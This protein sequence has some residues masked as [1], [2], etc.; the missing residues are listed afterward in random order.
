MT[1]PLTP[2]QLEK[3]RRVARDL[4]EHHAAG[5]RVNPDALAWARRVGDQAIN[6]TNGQAASTSEQGA[7]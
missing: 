4:L 5:G 1:T 2:E 6:D 7:A 3:M